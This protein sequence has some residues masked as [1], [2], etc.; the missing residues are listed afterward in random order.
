MQQSVWK[1][2]A[3]LK[4]GME[5]TGG[6]TNKATLVMLQRLIIATII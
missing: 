1:Y 2:L 5:A 4:N 6:V 3:S